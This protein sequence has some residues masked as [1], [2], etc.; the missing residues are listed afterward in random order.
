MYIIFEGIDTCGK[1]TQ[2]ELLKEKY[3]DIVFTFEPGGTELG[4]KIREILLNGHLDSKRAEILLF[5]ADRAEHF[6]SVIKPNLDNIII[7]DR[8]F[9]SGMAYAMANND[10]GFDELLKLNIFSLQGILPEKIILFIIDK[11]NLELRLGQKG[12]DKIEQRGIEYLL[13]VQQFMK[14]IV[15]KLGIPFLEINATDDME[16]INRQIK[17]F[18]WEQK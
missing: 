10:I 4:K 14:D 3:N 13:S 5:L 18:I 15:V 16:S 17:N 7:S 12:M 11:D 1:S 2:I 6:E 9:I 8:G